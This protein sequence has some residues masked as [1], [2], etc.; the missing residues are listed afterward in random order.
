M[1]WTPPALYK[2][3]CEINVEWFPFDVQSC[4]MVFSSWTY[5]GR[6]ASHQSFHIFTPT[7]I[8]HPDKW[9]E[10]SISMR[11]SR[12]IRRW[13]CCCCYYWCSDQPRKRILL[14]I[15]KFSPSTCL[16]LCLLVRILG[17]DV[18]HDYHELCF[19][20]KSQQSV[21]FVRRKWMIYDSIM[22]MKLWFG[23]KG[24]RFTLRVHLAQMKR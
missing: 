22:K 2:S 17:I 11:R 4:L 5:T 16:I 12:C 8:I 13:Y 18:G 19:E 1:K 24:Y 20:R 6:E 15:R 3:Y 21:I 10:K 14:W 9:F 7:L 23:I